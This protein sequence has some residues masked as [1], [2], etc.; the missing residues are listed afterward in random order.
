M[1]NSYRR[2]YTS[3]QK[4][5]EEHSK[6]ELIYGTIAA[7]LIRKG[8]LNPQNIFPVAKFLGFFVWLYSPIYSLYMNLKIKVKMAKIKHKQKG[9]GV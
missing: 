1:S 7:K 9:K 3:S 5:K 6:Y 8:R 4:P 2:G